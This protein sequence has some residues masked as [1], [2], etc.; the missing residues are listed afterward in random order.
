MADLK[1]VMI[2]GLESMEPEQLVEVAADAAEIH[3]MVM[4]EF[5]ARDER[6]AKAK[7]L[8]ASLKPGGSPAKGKPGRKPKAEKQTEPPPVADDELAAD[9]DAE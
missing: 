5:A 6:N 9:F 8:A 7:A 2:E 1:H 3:D 4:A